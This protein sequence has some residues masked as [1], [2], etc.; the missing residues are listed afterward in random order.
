MRCIIAF[1]L[2]SVIATS[3]FSYSSCAVS[4]VTPDQSN[5]QT[6]ALTTV[7]LKDLAQHYDFA[8][9]VRVTVR[10]VEAKYAREV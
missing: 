4:T 6:S 2:I 8:A 9:S 3:M 5:L 10:Q 7:V 1:F